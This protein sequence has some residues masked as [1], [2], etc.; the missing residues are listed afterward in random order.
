MTADLQL[1]R[2]VQVASLLG[3][4]RTTIWRWCRA[5]TFP[6]PIKIGR[7]ATGFRQSDVAAWLE[8]RPTST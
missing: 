4:D 3:V 1:L 2:P 8:S 7:S 5:G 6:A